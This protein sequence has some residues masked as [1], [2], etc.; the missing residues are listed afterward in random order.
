VEALVSGFV[1]HCIENH[2]FIVFVYFFT[3]AMLDGF[4]FR[5]EL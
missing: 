2:K 3:S 1:E 4:S 5:T